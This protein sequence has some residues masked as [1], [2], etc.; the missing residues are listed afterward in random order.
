[1]NKSAIKNYAVWARR[2]LISDVTIKAAQMGITEKGVSD[3]LHI[4]NS[5]IQYFNI[6]SNKPFELIGEDINK[7]HSLVNYIQE[8]A[9]TT[10]YV[11]AF[12]DVME[13]VAY[14]W[15]NRIIAIRF[16]EANDYMPNGIRVLSSN[17]KAK[18]EPDL[19]TQYMDADLDL[20]QFEIEKIRELTTKN[21]PDDVFK[22]LFLK[23]CNKLNEILPFLFEKT[24]DYSELLFQISYTDNDSVI[25]KLI[26]EVEES[27][28][29]EAVEIIGW[30][31]QFYISEKKDE[32]FAS[33]DKITKSSIS[34]VTQLFTPDWIVKYM[35]DNTLG[36]MWVES[37]EESALKKELLYYIDHDEQEER[38][39]KALEKISQ[40]N[41][42]KK[43]DEITFIDPC[44]GSGHVLVYAFDIFY[45][46]YLE[47]GYASSQIPSLIIQ[48]NLYGLDV[49]R[50]AMQLTCF[51]LTMKARSYD[52]RYLKKAAIQPNVLAVAESNAINIDA[53]NDIVKL[54]Q[55]SAKS[56]QALA[57]LVEKFKDAE[58][59]GS[60]IK[61]FT[62]T[63]EDFLVLKDELKNNLKNK[64][65]NLFDIQLLNNYKNLIT[66]LIDQAIIM[67]KK[68]DIMVTNPPYLSTSSNDKL[69]EFANKNYPD[70]KSDLFAMFMEVPFVKQNGYMAMINMHSWMFLSSYEKLREK[71]IATKD[72]VSMVHLGARAFEE[73]GGEVVQTTTFVIRDKV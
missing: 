35:T 8:K 1:M 71:L 21:K 6:G 24:Q 5:Q 13:E 28:F 72:I 25:R 37:H 48:N 62:Y 55:L 66:N 16:M 10:A 73:I 34:A 65:L 52:K 14:T 53:V 63:T 59:F 29:K 4:S 70:S 42:L 33:K 69:K 11:D 57:Y 3:P 51:A 9:K 47:Q 46:I 64:Q 44:S 12:R 22:L 50:R 7:R 38:V 18:K 49:D 41:A 32:V 2:K 43:A 19:V 56:G 58:L 26:S 60:L 36:K 23:Q 54:A 40:E 15:F 20:S 27:D 67:S 30:I 68:Y 17:N 61:N 45:K 39:K 31:Y